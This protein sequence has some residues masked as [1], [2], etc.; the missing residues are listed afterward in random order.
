M[1]RYGGRNWNVGF[2]DRSQDGVSDAQ[3]RL[4]RSLYGKDFRGLGYTKGQA[5]ALIQEGYH[6]RSINR[7]G[8]PDIADQMFSMYMRRA[9]EAANE[10][11]DVWL[12]EHQKVQFVVSTPQGMVEVH[13]PI[14]EASITA[15]KRGSGL[16][17]W[18]NEH[19]L[20]D[21]R[22]IKHLAVHHKYQDR[23]EGEL[24]LACAIAALRVFE[25]A[26]TEVGDIR[27]IYRCD[28]ADFQIPVAA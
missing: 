13:G 22:N 19:G 28:N 18:I 21:R 25:E 12:A 17:K 16:A 14:G 3:L 10:A 5:S 1:A 6:L 8:L 2:A 24:Q 15:P 9:I 27:V 20:N 7:S 4:L 26:K 11:G 23:L